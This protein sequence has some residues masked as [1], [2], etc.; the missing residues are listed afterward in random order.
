[1]N[2]QGFKKKN[3]IFKLQNTKCDPGILGVKKKNEKKKT[4]LLD[5]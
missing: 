1:M 2:F 3:S 4:N 5:K